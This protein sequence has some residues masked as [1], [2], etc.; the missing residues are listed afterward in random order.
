MNSAKLAM[1]R[2]LARAGDTERAWS[3]FNESGLAAETSHV[4]TLALKG[5]L[6]KDRALKAAAKERSPLLQAARQAYLQAAD[7]APATY[8]LINAATIALLDGNRA[9]AAEVAE[10]VMAMLDS[11]EHEG[12][13]AYWLG[14]TRAE[15]CLLLGRND[16]ARAALAD[17]VRQAPRAWEDLASTLRHFRLIHEMLGQSDD[18]LDAYRPP[19]SVHFSGIIH[20]APGQSGSAAISEALDTLRPGFGFG[21][22]AAGADIMAA[23]LLLERGAELHIA[24]PSSLESFRHDSVS[25]YGADWEGRF[26]AVIEAADSIDELDTLDQVSRSGVHVADEIAM[27]LAIRQA[28]MLETGATALRIGQG[29]RAKDTALDAAWQQR[30]LPVHHVALERTEPTAGSS[31]PVF[32][33]EAV[34]ALPGRH[35]ADELASAGGK[36][37][38]LGS[39]TIVRFE[40]PVA[41]AKAA[42]ARVR[43]G[44]A[45][46]GI[47]YDAYDPAASSVDRFETAIHIAGTAHPGRVPVSRSVALALTLEAPELRCE[48]YGTIASAQGDI[49]LSVLAPA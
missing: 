21:A 15:A 34:I 33:R 23:E 8:P 6:Y 14:A 17:A 35:E 29:T 49:A 5:R 44:E 16:D 9:Q 38:S 30:G 39:F 10:R 40:D 7:N 41:A 31:I 46:L 2:R 37:E 32:A 3:L 45:Q 18:W 13:T 11:G 25:R 12:D 47:A 28:R 26:D 48:N 20:V 27:G 19:A 43:E 42:L 36:V 1:I 4:D 22:L 24:L